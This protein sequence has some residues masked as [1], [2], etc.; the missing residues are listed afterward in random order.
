MSHSA[1]WDKKK[2]TVDMDKEARA[3]LARRNLPEHVKTRV[4][5]WMCSTYRTAECMELRCPRDNK[6]KFNWKMTVDNTL[7]FTYWLNEE[8]GL[9]VAPTKSYLPGLRQL[10]IMKGLPALKVHRGLVRQAMRRANMEVSQRNKELH[11]GNK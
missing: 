3:C 11:G 4:V 7:L 10:H 1:Y 2:V 6:V 9:K 5:N 8:K